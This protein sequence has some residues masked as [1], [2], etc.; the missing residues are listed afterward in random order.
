GIQPLI[1]EMLDRYL[2]VHH[3][4]TVRANGLSIREDGSWK[5]IWRD[6]SPHGVEKGR[7]LR[8][9]RANDLKNPN[10]D[11]IL[12]CGEASSDFAAALLAD[13]V[14]ARQNTSLEKLCRANLIPHRVFSTFDTVRDAVAEWIEEHPSIDDAN[15]P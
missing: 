1:E 5:I 9:A 15:E 2:G 6:S 11:H 4:I 12:W 14:L 7:A 10:T 3:G 8:E 13:V